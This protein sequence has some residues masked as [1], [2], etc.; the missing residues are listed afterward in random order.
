MKSILVLTTNNLGKLF[1]EFPLFRFNGMTMALFLFNRQFHLESVANMESNRRKRQSLNSSSNEPK[2]KRLALVQP[3]K[4]VDLN[5]DVLEE[6][7]SNLGIRDLVNV[8]NSDPAFLNSSRRAFKLKYKSDCVPV[9][10]FMDDDHPT[11][12][13]R[14]AQESELIRYFGESISCLELSLTNDSTDQRILHLIITCCSE[15][16]TELTILFPTVQL[17]FNKSFPNVRKL[18][19]SDGQLN[20]SPKQLV[21]WFP[22]LE[23]LVL[24]EMLDIGLLLNSKH[25]IPSLKCL[26]L[27]EHGYIG[28]YYRIQELNNFFA[29]NQQLNGI[30]LTLMNGNPVDEQ[31]L[32]TTASHSHAQI[33][34]NELMS[35][36]LTIDQ[37]GIEHSTSLANLN[38]TNARIAHLELC[39][40]YLTEQ[41]CDYIARCVNLNTL[42]VEINEYYNHWSD[43]FSE[44]G[45]TKL[46]KLDSLTRLEIF[47]PVDRHDAPHYHK[48][49][50]RMVA[51]FLRHM[52]S[53]T[54]I[55]VRFQIITHPLKPHNV[56]FEPIRSSIDVKVWSFT[57]KELPDEVLLTLAKITA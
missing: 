37:E 57:Y 45:W 47:T 33:I 30:T 41:I 2:S 18:S 13:K 35:V 14:L 53:I 10:F 39:L 50:W 32:P 19:F 40:D 3:L 5:E 28:P 7:F 23:S 49:V 54:T 15:T 55:V 56:F 21:K 8:V 52:K 44:A 9:P 24:E 29:V 25:K 42:K 46:K 36:K 31:Q 12:R 17:K 11:T 1:C 27:E 38:I 34:S 51:P 48:I 20:L 22:S 26:T 6:I 43:S 4:L 16:L